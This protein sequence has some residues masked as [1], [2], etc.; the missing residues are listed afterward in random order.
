M[1]DLFGVAVC[2]CI[3]WKAFCNPNMLPFVPSYQA[4]A[5][6]RLIP[7]PLF[8]IMSPCLFTGSIFSNLLELGFLGLPFPLGCLVFARKLLLLTSRSR[9][10]A[11][12]QWPPVPTQKGADRAGVTL[13]RLLGL[14]TATIK[15]ET[16]ER[17]G[18]ANP[19][20]EGPGR[21]RKKTKRGHSFW[22]KRSQRTDTNKRDSAIEQVGS[23]C[24]ASLLSLVDSPTW[25]WP[26]L[27]PPAS[28]SSSDQAQFR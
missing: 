8:Y 6:G 18:G 16:R 25:Q 15:K 20:P 11:N 3:F 14:T 5:R 2:H 17:G 4:V 7:S 19:E 23:L 13:P 28:P 9:A 27:W 22:E 26:W 24:L 21:G 1:A 12:H 10:P